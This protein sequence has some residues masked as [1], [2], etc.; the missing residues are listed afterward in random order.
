MK[1]FYLP[2]GV[3]VIVIAFFVYNAT[4]K[5]GTD[6]AKVDFPAAP[7]SIYLP[8]SP[9]GTSDALCRMFEKLAPKYIKQPVVVVNKAG[10]GGVIATTEFQSVKPDGY[11]VLLGLSGVFTTV[12]HMR[13]V[14]YDINNFKHVIG[15]TYEPN[16]LVVK[17]DSPY[18]TFQNL[19]DAYKG[20]K[21][22]VY[23]HNG[24][25]SLLHLDQAMLYEQAGIKAEGVPYGGTNEALSALLG[26]H[27]QAIAMGPGEL[28]PHLEDG[29]VR[30]LC[31]FGEKR[32]TREAFAEIPSSTELGYK[33]NFAVW[34]FLTVPKDTPDEIVAKLYVIFA[35]MLLDPEFIKYADDNALIV[36]SYTG[37]EIKI[38]IA[39]ENKLG[40]ETIESLG[41]SE[42]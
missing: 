9:G 25:G 10:A 42:K 1:K 16:F 37:E 5:K 14:D 23:G 18:K 31:V 12:P 40:Q 3:L 6:S 13:K 33:A 17:A 24:S 34:K 22:L 19:V 26:G 2:L 35:K 27:V 8:S 28:K 36:T 32:D 41:I 38:K 39:A 4:S 30:A 15:L 20:K 21:S 29:T 11:T 7:I